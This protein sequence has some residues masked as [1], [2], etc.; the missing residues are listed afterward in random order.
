MPGRAGVLNAAPPALDSVSR[1]EALPGPVYRGVLPAPTP[2]PRVGGGTLMRKPC[3]TPLAT[4]WMA[5]FLGA[6][7]T[8]RSKAK[9]FSSASRAPGFKANLIVCLLHAR[10]RSSSRA[11]L[12]RPL[13]VALRRSRSI[14][15]VI[16]GAFEAGC[17]ECE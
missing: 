6:S 1:W 13:P 16:E 11:G 3:L 12:K 8:R 5:L 2:T 7:R 14:S 10:V 4:P 9:R 17:G 15:S